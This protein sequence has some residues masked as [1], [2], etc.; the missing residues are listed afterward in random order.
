MLFLQG[1]RDG[2]ADLVLLEPL[3]ATVEPT[4]VLHVVEGADHGFHVLR[5]S[6][7]TDQDVLEELCVRLAS[8]MEKM[9]ED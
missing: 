3:L 4:P 1:T 8:W 6:G 5:K 2:L 7:R 9:L